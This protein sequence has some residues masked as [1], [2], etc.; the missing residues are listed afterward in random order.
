[1]YVYE[2]RPKRNL[3][4]SEGEKKTERKKK[5][6]EDKPHGRIL[7]LLT[8]SNQEKETPLGNWYWVGV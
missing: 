8:H 4:L 2:Y 5:E 1:M 3:V 7:H 6:E